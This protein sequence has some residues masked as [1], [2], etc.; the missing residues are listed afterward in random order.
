MNVRMKI[1]LSIVTVTVLTALVVGFVGVSNARTLVE[2]AEAKAVTD[3][4]RTL[5]SYLKNM[6]EDIVR[7]ALMAARNPLIIEGLAEVI[8]GGDR[9]KL[10]DA[11]LYITQYSNIDFYSVM[12]ME[13]T[14]MM[15]SHQPDRFGDKSNVA[16]DHVRAAM[17]GRQLTAYE[18]TAGNPVALRCGVPIMHQGKQIG[19]MSGGY[20]LSSNAFVD[21]FKSF[22]GNDVTIFLGDTRVATTILNEKGERNVGTKTA[23][24][25]SRQVLDG[26]EY[27][28]RTKAVGRD[29]YA[30]YAPI[31][32]VDGKAFGMTFVGLDITETQ[33]QLRNVIVM[34]VTIV[35]IFCAIAGILGFF[36]ANGIAKPLAAAVKMIQELQKGHLGIRLNMRGR[37]DEIDNMAN[38]MDRFADELQQNLVGVMKQIADGDLSANIV[39]EDDLDEISP[40]LQN[41]ID[42]LR[43]LIIE[44]GG[45]VLNAAAEKDMSQRLSRSYKGQF[46]R[47]KE[48]IDK[49][50]STLDDALS[51]VSEAASQVTQAST[52]ISGGSQ[53]LAESSNEQASHLEEVSSSL[54]EMSSMTKQNA[55]NSNQA[56]ILAAE[57]RTAANEGDKA[58][59][60][61]ADAIQQI[62]TSSDNTAK[63]VKT[64]DEIAFQTNLLA[65]NAAVEAARA[66]EAG[67]GFA[68]V[69]EEVRNLAMRSAEAAKNTTEMI[70]E[71]VKNAEGGVKI[72]QEVAKALTQI[73][74]RVG[75]VGDLIGEIAAASKEQALGIEQV[76]TAVAQMNQA[77][78]QNAANSEESAAAAE[79]LSGQASELANMVSAFKLSSSAGSRYRGQS[80]HSLPPPPKKQY[81]GIPDKRANK[82]KALPAP[83]SKA[84]KAEQI[85]P[86]NDNELSEF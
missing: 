78:Q 71:S 72:T 67:K 38:T 66:G 68:V 47:M 20:L 25:I 19:V 29:M 5:V 75:K 85:I 82:P 80:K 39:P 40:A 48:S 31:R 22:N 63:I 32:G 64:I 2:G 33:K 83:S 76:N 14:T 28:G 52:E 24:N 45:K 17:A 10:V 8:K 49:V 18:T 61:M 30:H 16:L 51:Q 1:L 59:K 41:T 77:T 35:L 3:A 54:E 27:F 13:G 34:M 6:E 62:K 60:N 73:V 23:E 57:A 56:K 11:T 44:D 36:I 86:L 21:K 69:A 43:G 55:D 81:A 79:E 70:E 26:D 74:D 53:S 4:K 50:V 12:D 15:R 46:A 9:Q 84:V 65:L 37:K 58:M 42:S 7:G